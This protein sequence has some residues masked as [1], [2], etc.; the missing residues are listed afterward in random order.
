MHVYNRHAQF[1]PDTWGEMDGPSLSCKSQE[2]GPDAA[3]LTTI[4]G[5]CNVDNDTI[6]YVYNKYEGKRES[7]GYGEREREREREGD[8]CKVISCV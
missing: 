4:F 3:S 2:S 6:H 5:M 1:A 7:E 8:V